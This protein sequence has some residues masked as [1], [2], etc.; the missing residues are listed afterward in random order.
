MGEVAKEAVRGNPDFFAIKPTDY[1]R[2]LVISLGTGSPKDEMKYTAEKAAKWGLLQWLT[3]GGSTPI[4]DVFSHASSDI[5]DFHLSVVF[6]ALHCENNYLRIQDDTLSDVVSS[7]DVATK[8]NLN[9]LV[10]V[11]EN[12]LK[13]PVSRVNLETG[14]FEASNAETNEQALIR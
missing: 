11:G 7:V 2:F 8:N 4:I 9:A 5:V 1:S 10:E 13:K 6:K 14:V 3:A 12:L